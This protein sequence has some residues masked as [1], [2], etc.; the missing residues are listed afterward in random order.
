ML[1]KK[2]PVGFI[3]KKVSRDPI[4]IIEVS[5]VSEYPLVIDSRFHHFPASIVVFAYWRVKGA[6][7]V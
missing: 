1:W 7:Q 5:L 2:D 3:F 6:A 4:G